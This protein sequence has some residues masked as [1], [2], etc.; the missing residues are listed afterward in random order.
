VV[1]VNGKPLDK[2][3]YKVYADA[4][5]LSKARALRHGDKAEIFQPLDK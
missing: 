2:R 1:V 5:E 3:S 4:V